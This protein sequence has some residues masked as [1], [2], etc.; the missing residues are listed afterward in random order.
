MAAWM[1]WVLFG[2][3]MAAIAVGIDSALRR[4]RKIRETAG[5]LG[6]TY[7]SH[8]DNLAKELEGKVPMFEHEA[9]VCDNVTA[10]K[11]LFGNCHLFRLSY[12]SRNAAGRPDRESIGLVACLRS[13]RPVAE[14]VNPQRVAAVS[15]RWEVEHDG[16]W[17]A[18]RRRSD[19]GDDGYSA[20]QLREYHTEVQ[21]LLAMVFGTTA[22]R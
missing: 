4:A 20:E 1:G 5:Q 14:Q 2:L 13:S 7:R 10:Y 12:I 9:I 15:D 3:L 21:K 19:R 6:M 11:T 22:T 17:L 16:V 18:M 8:D